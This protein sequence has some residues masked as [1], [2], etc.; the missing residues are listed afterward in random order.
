MYVIL[1]KLPPEIRRNLARAHTDPKWTITDLQAGTCILTELRVF[2]S[3]ESLAA[4]ECTLESPDSTLS[5]ITT[6]LFTGTGRYKQSRHSVPTVIQWTIP[7]L[8]VTLLLTQEKEWT[9]FVKTICVL[10]VWVDTELPSVDQRHD[11]ST[12]EGSITLA[13]V[14]LQQTRIR[15]NNQSRNLHL[16]LTRRVHRRI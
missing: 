12:V 14:R 6:W 10:I 1:A 2:E 3:G 13:Y 5:T 8:L 9:L 4:S 16:H 15:T 7:Y 11:A